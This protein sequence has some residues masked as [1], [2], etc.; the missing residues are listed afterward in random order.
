MQLHRRTDQSALFQ[1]MDDHEI[2]RRESEVVCNAFENEEKC[3]VM[4]GFR[5]LHKLVDAVNTDAFLDRRFVIFSA[6]FARNDK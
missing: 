3:R 4:K 6:Q 2:W 5:T 1:G